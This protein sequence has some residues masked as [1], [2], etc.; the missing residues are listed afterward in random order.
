MTSAGDA[1]ASA[2]TVGQRSSHRCH[3]GTTRSTWVCC[4]MTSLTR[5]AYGS[6]V[7]RQGSSL[8]VSRYQSRRSSC[9]RGSLTGSRFRLEPADDPGVR[10]DAL[11]RLL[12]RSDALPLGNRAALA[13]IVALCDEPSATPAGIALEAARR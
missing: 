8:P 12:E 10:S 6:R 5:M 7:R 11:E 3:L 4:A 1:A 9:T 2:S 13:R